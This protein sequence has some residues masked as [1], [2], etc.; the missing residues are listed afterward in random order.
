MNSMEVLDFELERKL[1]TDAPVD[2]LVQGEIVYSRYIPVRYGHP[3]DAY[4]DVSFLI[5]S[6][7]YARDRALY[8]KNEDTQ[9]MA[10]LLDGCA[11]IAAKALKEAQDE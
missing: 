10:C 1:M 7:Q 9:L 11:R 8:S 4:D 5:D 2:R 3:H 6:L